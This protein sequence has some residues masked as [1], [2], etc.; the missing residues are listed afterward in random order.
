MLEPAVVEQETFRLAIFEKEF[1]I[2]SAL[3]SMVEALVDPVAVQPRTIDQGG[4]WHH[5]R[6]DRLQISRRYLPRARGEINMP[7]RYVAAAAIARLMF[8][9]PKHD[10]SH[11][12]RLWNLRIFNGDEALP[13]P[14]HL[15][16]SG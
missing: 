9:L 7:G 8:R 3:K 12:A 1:A 14:H 2:I 5:R 15:V 11:M 13:L 10:G 16:A 4:C 6:H